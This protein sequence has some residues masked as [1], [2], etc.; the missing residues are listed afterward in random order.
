MDK[1][2]KEEFM[3]LVKETMKEKEI[4]TRKLEPLTGICY[5]EISRKLNGINSITL[6]QAIIF[7]NA[8]EI[9]LQFAFDIFPECSLSENNVLIGDSNLND[10]FNNLSLVDKKRVTDYII[11]LLDNEVSSKTKESVSNL[12]L[13]LKNNK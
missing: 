5:A 13:S 1:Q 9:P 8:L 12:V 6:E 4:S 11:F 7:C 10:R 2:A 3:K